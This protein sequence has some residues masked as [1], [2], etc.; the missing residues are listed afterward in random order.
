MRLMIDDSIG[1]L[2]AHYRASKL[3][4]GLYKYGAQVN[5]IMI[6]ACLIRCVAAAVGMGIAG[7]AAAQESA[8]PASESA[9]AAESVRTRQRTIERA[10]AFLTD[11]A[12]KWRKERGCATCHHGTMTVWALSEARNQGFELSE[13]YLS[14]AVRWT[15]GR[16]VPNLSKPRDPRPGWS[17]VSVPAI[18]LGVMSQNL[19]ILS[20][21]EIHLVSSHL[22]RHIEGDGSWAMPPPLNGAPPIWESPETLALWAW[23]A[24]EPHAPADPQEAETARVNREKAAAWLRDASPTG[25][26]QATMLRLLLAT[27]MGQDQQQVQSGI[28]QLLQTQNTDG[29][30]RQVPELPSDAFATGQALY[31]LSFAGVAHERPEI[32]RA[33]SFLV[34]TQ[35]EDGSWPMTSHNHPGVTSTRDPIRNPVPITYFGSAWAALGLVR[36]VAPPPDTPE[37]RQLAFDEIQAFHGKYGLDEQDADKPVVL[38]DLRYYEIEDAQLARFADVLQAFPRLT[39]L[40][41]K[42]TKITDAGLEHLKR[43]N[44]LRSL[45]VE[46]SAIT[47]NGL[48]A[49]K[50]LTRLEELTLKGGQVT[51]AGVAA[52]QQALPALKVVRD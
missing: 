2:T 39:T 1:G 48:A 18:Y 17:L 26:T 15:K 35:R 49:L 9:L 27:R 3:A 46:D 36:F 8:P 29:G 7:S 14:E 30:W 12:A 44:Q 51:D 43:L 32:G 31:A 22:A 41:L 6:R 13:D 45:T 24:W 37:K 25:T 34:G 28:D 21:D 4:L 19:P 23:L 40:Q 52:L 20:R 33:I 42:S 50:D 38:V 11:D 5:P 47:D 10:V 16:F